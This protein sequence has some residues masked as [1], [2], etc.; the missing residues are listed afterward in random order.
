[1][2]RNIIFVIFWSVQKTVRYFQRK[3]PTNWMNNSTSITLIRYDSYR[4]NIPLMRKS[5]T[6]YRLNFVIRYRIH[7][8]L[9]WPLENG[10]D[11]FFILWKNS[12]AKAIHVTL[13]KRKLYWL[14]TITW[15]M[16]R[17]ILQ[18]KVCRSTCVEILVVRS[19]DCELW[20]RSIHI[21]NFHK[22][23]ISDIRFHL[24]LSTRVLEL[25]F[26]HRLMSQ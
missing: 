12:A 1:M 8:R 17:N 25:L 4:F 10:R 23:I 21:V 9:A 26:A 24:Q 3:L 11:I 14:R 6:R 16:R 2:T 7:R 5:G 13:F 15:R 22:A 19:P 20:L 18:V